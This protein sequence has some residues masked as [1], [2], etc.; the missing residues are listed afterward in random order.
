MLNVQ[1]L[2]SHFPL[3]MNYDMKQSFLLRLNLF[4][5]CIFF[6]K[7]HNEPE[8]LFDNSYIVLHIKYSTI[9]HLNIHTTMG[10]NYEY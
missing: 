4:V 3:D 6:P 1:F 5:F 2:Q 7:L 8:F 9:L 10:G